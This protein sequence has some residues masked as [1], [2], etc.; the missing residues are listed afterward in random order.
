MF[1]HLKNSGDMVAPFGVSQHIK[2][3]NDTEYV[4]CSNKRD[5]SEFFMILHGWI[6]LCILSTKYYGEFHE[7]I[8]IT[9]QVMINFRF[10]DSLLQL[11]EID[12]SN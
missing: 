11:S 8:L 9:S 2:K 6:A 7:K 3:I 1:I 4:N 12:F 5:H 10:S